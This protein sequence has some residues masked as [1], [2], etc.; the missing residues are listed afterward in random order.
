M[1]TGI[2]AMDR[3]RTFR[4][5]THTHGHT[6][7]DAQTHRHTDTHT[8]R[9]QLRGESSGSTIAYAAVAR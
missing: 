3:A 7:T 2:S 9:P 5:E 8:H 1:E 4:G 6:H